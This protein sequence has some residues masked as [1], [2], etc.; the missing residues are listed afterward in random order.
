M[1]PQ[2]NPTTPIKRATTT[3]SY[4]VLPG[5]SATGKPGVPTR[6][7][8][9]GCRQ[10]GGRHRRRVNGSS[11]STPIKTETPSHWGHRPRIICFITFWRRTPSSTHRYKKRNHRRASTERVLF[12]CC[13]CYQ[14]SQS[15]PSFRFLDVEINA[16]SWAQNECLLFCR[17]GSE[18]FFTQSHQKKV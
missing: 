2:R 15:R 14:N 16:L 17:S 5:F 11:N 18:P 13:C 8:F 4:L 3:E 12:C 6:Q 1:N 9:G 10:T 7:P